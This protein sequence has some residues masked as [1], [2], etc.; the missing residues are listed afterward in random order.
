MVRN[1]F[2]AFSDLIRKLQFSIMTLQKIPMNS[3]SFLQITTV[4]LK[5]RE[6]KHYIEWGSAENDD[7]S[8]SGRINGSP[9]ND[10]HSHAENDCHVELGSL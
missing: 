7:D 9:G 3:S 4:A 8:R 1:N 10:D 5:L 6:I 2:P